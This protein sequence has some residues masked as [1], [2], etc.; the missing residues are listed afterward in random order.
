M[1]PEKRIRL[2]S[3]IDVSPVVLQQVREDHSHCQF[4]FLHF[5]GWT[6][7]GFSPPERID[8]FR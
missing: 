1:A 5:I 8:G 2:L 7:A 6:G 4:Q 3:R